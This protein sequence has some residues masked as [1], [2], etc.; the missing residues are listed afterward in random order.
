MP[1][2]MCLNCSHTLRPWLSS[3]SQ[4]ICMKAV[5]PLAFYA[6][7]YRAT[8]T[9]NRYLLARGMVSVST[10]IFGTNYEMSICED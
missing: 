8:Q 6:P 5:R 3:C 10:T 9:L 4:G 2:I 1:L 7:E